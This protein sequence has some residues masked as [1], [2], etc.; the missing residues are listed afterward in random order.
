MDSV[1]EARGRSVVITKAEGGGRN[2]SAV[3][4]AFVFSYLIAVET[5]TE[6]AYNTN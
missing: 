5:R 1:E 6:A 3:P 4:V 2:E